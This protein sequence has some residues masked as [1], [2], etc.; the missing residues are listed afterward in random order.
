MKKIF[1][2]LFAAGALLGSCDMNLEPIGQLPSDGSV[3]S[4][5]DLEALRNGAYRNMRIIT[6]SGNLLGSEIQM[7]DFVGVSTNGNVY[8][9]LSAGSLLSSNSDVNVCWQNMYYIITGVNYDL[10]EAQRLLDENAIEETDMALYN[11]YVGELKFMRAYAYWWLVDHFCQPYT[12]ENGDTE[13]LGVPLRLDF[14]PTGD[15]STYPGRST[16]NQTFTQ[17]EKDLQEAYDALVAY[18]ATG[19]K[20]VAEL[21]APNSYYVSS[22]VVKAMQAR[23]ALLKGDYPTAFNRAKEVIDSQIYP[24][25]AYNRYITMWD[26]D[27]GTEVLMRLFMS[28]TETG[29]IGGTGLQFYTINNSANYIPVNDLISLYDTRNDIR[30]TAWFFTGQIPVMGRNYRAVFMGGKYPGNMDLEVDPTQRQEGLNMAKPFRTAEMYLIAAEAD[31][32]QNH[33]P[34]GLAATYLND[35]RRARIQNYTDVTFN[36]ESELRTAIRNERRKELVAEGFRM[37]DLRRWGLGFT[38]TGSYPDN[39]ELESILAPTSVGVT[40]QAGDYRYTWPIPA[41]E[42]ESNPQL[43][44]QQNP[45]Y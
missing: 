21:V 43:A 22:Y 29:G 32:E 35:L 15:N 42:M 4:I 19:A 45:N 30:Y 18:E 24:L 1:L 37:S 33:N 28:S 36:S 31:L 14:N 7:D 8:G 27:E 38:R 40:Y 5:D 25:T 11:R 26:N 9:E 39:P 10:I 44:G 17:I 6:T 3:Q 2:T 41:D 34:Q 20:D 23:V 16:L 12:E 13:A